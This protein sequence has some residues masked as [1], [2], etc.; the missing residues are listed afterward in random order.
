LASIPLFMQVSRRST[1]PNVQLE[2][3][4]DGVSGGVP[5]VMGGVLLRVRG[6]GG[7]ASVSERGPIPRPTV[8]ATQACRASAKLRRHDDPLLPPPASRARLSAPAVGRCLPDRLASRAPGES[9]CLNGLRPK[10]P[11]SR[12]ASRDSSPRISGGTGTALPLP[13]IRGFDMRERDGLGVLC[14]LCDDRGTT[15]S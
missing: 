11:P 12:A 7:R 8:E 6:C 2:R 13:V 1:V 10:A 5:T 4:V 15:G 14:Q 9:A 3:P